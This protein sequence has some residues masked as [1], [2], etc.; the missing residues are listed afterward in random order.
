MSKNIEARLAKVEKRIND[1]EGKYD[2]EQWVFD[3]VLGTKA[4]VL[5]EELTER[6]QKALAEMIEKKNI[7]TTIQ[8]GNNKWFLTT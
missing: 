4:T 3:V 7:I 8:R 6:Q 1:I 2:Q 5:E